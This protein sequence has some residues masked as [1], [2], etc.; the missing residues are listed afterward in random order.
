[1]ENNNLFSRKKLFFQVFLVDAERCC[2]NPEIPAVA[3][4]DDCGVCCQKT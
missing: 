1:M 3:D 4:C 2:N